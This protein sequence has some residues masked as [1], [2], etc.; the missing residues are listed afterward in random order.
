MGVMNAIV[1]WVIVVIMG[2]ATFF[3]DYGVVALSYKFFLSAPILVTILDLVW[4]I[5]LALVLPFT[6]H[7]F[8]WITTVAIATIASASVY[9]LWR[10][11]PELFNA[12]PW[13]MW[14]VVVAS[15]AVGWLL[16]STPMWRWAKGMLP[17]AQSEQPGPHH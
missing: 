7:M 5:G 14:L 16:V 11:L 4:V 15:I 1:R 6:L 17:V 13:Y 12:W 9:L 10:D 2:I 3:P 8:R